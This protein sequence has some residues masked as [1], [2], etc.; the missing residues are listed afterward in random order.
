LFEKQPFEIGKGR[1]IRPGKDITVVSTGSITANAFEAARIL[2]QQG[3][4]VELIGMPTVWPVDKALI[5]QS[6][7]KTRRVVTIEEHYV[8]GG[9]GTIVQEICSEFQPTPVKKLGVPHEYATSG[10]YAE[11]LSHY[12]LDASSIADSIKSF[13]KLPVNTN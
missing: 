11:L 10:P 9:L 7:A 1:V 5:Q 3:I 12:G 6:S 13:V 4:D 2:E 8:I